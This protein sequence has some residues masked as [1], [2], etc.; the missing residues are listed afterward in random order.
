M[1]PRVGLSYSLWLQP[2]AAGLPLLA[3]YLFDVT[4]GYHAAVIVA[5]C[6]NM[7]GV[8]LALGLPRQDNRQSVVREGT[9][10]D[11]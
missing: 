4:G 7:L 11:G 6:G 10:D 8:G 3:G 5:G 9:I 1:T 2:V